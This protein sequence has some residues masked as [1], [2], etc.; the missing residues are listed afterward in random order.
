[1]TGLLQYIMH[2]DKEEEQKQNAV[3]PAHHS[4]AGYSEERRHSYGENRRR[5]E[6]H[7][8]DLVDHYVPG[9]SDGSDQCD[10]PDYHKNVEDVASHYVPDG[11][12]GIAL[13]GGSDADG[14]FRR[15]CA[16]RHDGQT[17]HKVRHTPA[18]CQSRGSVGKDVGASHYQCE[19]RNEYEYIPEHV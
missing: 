10:R 9:D 14:Q 1:M 11:Y 15:G 4:R 18:A 19:S 6:D 17:H 8:R 7:H 13:N 3:H 16:E 5:G 2:E 12:P